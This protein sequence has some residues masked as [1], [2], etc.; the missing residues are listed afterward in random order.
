M[1]TCADFLRRRSMPPTRRRGAGSA[2]GTAATPRAVLWPDPLT[3]PRNN[4]CV[5]TSTLRAGPGRFGRIELE[6]PPVRSR[7]W[8]PRV[9]QRA[10]AAGAQRQTP[11]P[12]SAYRSSTPEIAG[13][14]RGPPGLTMMCAGGCANVD[15][16]VKTAPAPSDGSSPPRRLKPAREYAASWTAPSYE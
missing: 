5:F 15:G 16:Q 11:R 3:G 2:L 7:D 6:R 4:S 10:K 12:G 14:F 9:S 1:S 13:V 8:P